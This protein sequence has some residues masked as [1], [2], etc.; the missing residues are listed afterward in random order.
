[1]Q[2]REGWDRRFP[3]VRATKLVL[4]LG[5]ELQTNCAALHAV[6]I[7]RHSV[8]RS[9]HHF[10]RAAERQLAGRQP[11][12]LDDRTE[13]VAR[14]SHHVFITQGQVARTRGVA[15]SSILR[16][17]STSSTRP[18]STEPRVEAGLP[19]P[20]VQC[21]RR[22]ACSTSRPHHVDHGRGAE[23][24]GP[25]RAVTPGATLPQGASMSRPRSPT[26]SQC[27]RR[28]TAPSTHRHNAPQ[29][30]T[31]GDFHS[32]RCA[33]DAEGDEIARVSSRSSRT[34]SNV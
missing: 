22:C 2:H 28:R 8:V 9:K 30:A 34:E 14:G 5:V 16:R 10:V 32:W 11:E 19:V 25:R 20:T 15:G 23:Q 3:A 29:P 17:R 4:P 24:S 18:S 31:A 13:L 6:G 33:K 1:M 12:S 7:A 21:S 27:A 26:W